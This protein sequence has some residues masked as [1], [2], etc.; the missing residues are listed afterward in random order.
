[1]TI[2]QALH[3]ELDVLSAELVGLIEVALG[4]LFIL[5]PTAIIH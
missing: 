5:T 2:L 4:D 1:M 3:A